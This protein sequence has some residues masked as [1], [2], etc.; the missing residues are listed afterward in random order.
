MKKTRLAAMS[1]ILLLAFNL[2]AQ[3]NNSELVTINK[4]FNA[5]T[6]L[7]YNPDTGII[8]KDADISIEADSL[9]FSDKEA[10]SL[11]DNVKIDFPGGLLNSSN[12]LI[13]ASKELIEFKKDTTLSLEQ[14]L[15]KG[16][17]GFFN[18]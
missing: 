8:I 15:L 12:A 1:V 9:R 16:D 18:I 14:I 4:S 17:E 6:C 2:N 7:I 3:S 5:T 10:I 13:G 11:N